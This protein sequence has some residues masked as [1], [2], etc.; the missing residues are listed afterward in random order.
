[1]LYFGS[2]DIQIDEPNTTTASTSSPD[3]KNKQKGK[4]IQNLYHILTTKISNS[5]FLLLANKLQSDREKLFQ[6][7]TN[8]DVKPRVRTP[9][10]IM[11]AYSKTG[12]MLNCPSFLFSLF[13][14]Y[15]FQWAK[16]ITIV[17]FQDAASVASQTRNKLM[18]RQEK[19]EVDIFLTYI[20]LETC[21]FS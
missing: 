6:G 16:Y 18:E 20:S 5:F 21:Q 11:V 17:W 4:L 10:E 14:L 13:I 19:L 2:D 9:E 7:G 8:D 3:V 15:C 1:M 12:V